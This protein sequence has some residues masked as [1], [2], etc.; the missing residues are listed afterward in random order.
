MT[1]S[2]EKVE[3]R[4]NGWNLKHTIGHLLC[5][6]IMVDSANGDRLVVGAAQQNERVTA[7]VSGPLQLAPGKLSVRIWRADPGDSDPQEVN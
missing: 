6:V 1:W 2:A 7:G 4:C 5:T 3:E